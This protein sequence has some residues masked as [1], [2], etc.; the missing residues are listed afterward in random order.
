M[1]GLFA[2]TGGMSGRIGLPH[3]RLMAE[4][5]P[6][7]D[8]EAPPWMVKGARVLHSTFGPGMV[9]RVGTYKDVPSVWV[10][11]DNGQTT[12]LALEFA[13][14]HMAPEPASGTKRKRWFGRG[15][16]ARKP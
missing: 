11:F 5:E 6:D 12:G 2:S 7:L 8:V 1:V 14:P 16:A 9:G 3:S 13:L 15:A 10:D 4:W